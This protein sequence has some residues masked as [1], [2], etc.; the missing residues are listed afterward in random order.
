MEIDHPL[1]RHFS[2]QLIDWL[3]TQ[4]RAMVEIDQPT[5]HDPRYPDNPKDCFK[6]STYLSCMRPHT[7]YYEGVYES[8]SLPGVW[9][10]HAWAR[11]LKTDTI[12]ENTSRTHPT[13]SYWGL[14]IPS[15]ILSDHITTQQY[16]GVF[17]GPLGFDPVTINRF[18]DYFAPKQAAQG[19]TA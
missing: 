4:P 16:Y 2:G 19:Q 13:R 11:C 6:N 17:N 18:P 7:E 9:L 5:I 8:Y 1:T 14:L 15:H 3:K 12:I 10:P